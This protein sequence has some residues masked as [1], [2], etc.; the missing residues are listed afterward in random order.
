MLASSLD[1]RTA[2]ASTTK[3]PSRSSRDHRRFVAIATRLPRRLQAI[4]A[5]ALVLLVWR[6][7][8]HPRASTSSLGPRPAP[9]SSPTSAPRVRFA[10]TRPRPPSARLRFANGAT[11]HV[12][13]RPRNDAQDS[14]EALWET[15]PVVRVDLP[16][17]AR[18]RWVGDEGLAGVVE[19]GRGDDC[20]D[21]A[22]EGWTSTRL[23]VDVETGLR[24]LRDA[25]PAD[26]LVVELPSSAP[27]APTDV[28]LVTQLSV[29]R[30]ARLDRLLA[31]WDGPISAAIYLVDE[32]DIATLSA[33][34]SPTRLSSPDWHRVSLVIVKPDFSVTE[35]ALVERLRYPINRLRNL[36]L[37]AAPSPYTL[38]IDVDFVP[39]PKLHSV[40]VER[41]VPLIERAQHSSLGARSPTLRPVA[42]VVPTFALS[43][44]FDGTYPNST[45]ELKALFTADPPV[46][47]LTDANAGHGPTLPSLLFHLSRTSSS[48]PSS[49]L[50]PGAPDPSH[51]Y[52]LCYEP[53]WE[54]YYLVSIA[55]HPLYDE[56]FTDQGG[57]KQAHAL[58]LN[59]LGFE[60]RAVVGPERD[61]AW[62][63]H[64]PKVDRE[65]EAWPAAR[66][67]QRHGR[68][69]HA[70]AA[71]GALVGGA[72]EPG[73]QEPG[74]EDEEQEDAH[75]NLAAQ[76][77][78]SRFRYFEDFLPE[79]ERT[80]SANV[81]WPRG[82]GASVVGG[83]RSFGRARAG[84]VFGL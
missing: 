33:H 16:L 69:E 11:Q 36:A 76:R 78:H 60:F 37:A 43:S 6:T 65:D 49:P 19:R 54:P 74:E 30:L 68:P 44:A 57:D 56:R 80:W 1:S 21:K 51:S 26:P 31:A 62:V 4:L 9:S 52:E 47:T 12:Y 5:L 58:I 61:G 24:Q 81:R 3:S 70:R 41:G 66:L 34:L 77:D 72:A 59:A 25:D 67:V 23:E 14:N 7:A 18:L 82:C 79:V 63:V 10:P 48:T 38:V 15:S 71:E 45:A 32:P 50:P 28:T 13:P 8:K 64:P 2:T 27:V 55:S 73:E 83:G 20:A 29:S 53:Q 17:G 40:L 75:F 39:S 35:A 22:C 46:A 84:S 42:V